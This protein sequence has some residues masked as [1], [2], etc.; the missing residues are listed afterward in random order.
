MGQ[1]VAACSFSLA[2]LTVR[3]T[4]PG[5]GI[6][7]ELPWAVGCFVGSN[8]VGILKKGCD[9]GLKV[10]VKDQEE[11]EQALREF[12]RKVQEQGLVREMRRRAHYIPPAEARKIK[13][14]RARGRRSR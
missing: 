13:S 6:L 12:R 9:Q 10:I 3:A 2:R 14:L 4:V 7:V 11:F 8:L 1:H 5:H